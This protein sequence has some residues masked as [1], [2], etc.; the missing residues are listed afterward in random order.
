MF[1]SR[2]TKANVLTSLP[3]A[4]SVG[5]NTIFRVTDIGVAG[6]TLISDGTRWRPQGGSAVLHRQTADIAHADNVTEQAGMIATIPAGLLGAGDILRVTQTIFRSA[7]DTDVFDVRSRFGTSSAGLTGT[8]IKLNTMVAATSLTFSTVMEFRLISATS[9]IMLGTDAFESY[10]GISAIAQA[11][12]VTIPSTD[13]ATM[14][15]SNTTQKTA[16]TLTTFA[17][18]RGSRLEWITG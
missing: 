18:V 8:Q 13:A 6:I 16:D 12:A 5:V 7:A 4:T 2:L 3:A 15:W 14:Y 11:V 10:S 9:I 1:P 17:T